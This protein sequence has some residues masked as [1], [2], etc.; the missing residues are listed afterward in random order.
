MINTEPIVVDTPPE[1]VNPGTGSPPAD[2]HIQTIEEA[3]VYSAKLAADGVAKLQDY[4]RHERMIAKLRVYTRQEVLA[5]KAREFTQ[6]D[7]FLFQQEL[8]KLEQPVRLIGKRLDQSEVNVA[9]IYNDLATAHNQLAYILS[10]L[11]PRKN[12]PGRESVRKALKLLGPVIQILK[13]QAEQK[14]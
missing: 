8:A 2:V 4:F 11:P 12:A 7:E 3:I 13:P 6:E 5:G 9:D 14:E 10:I 1:P